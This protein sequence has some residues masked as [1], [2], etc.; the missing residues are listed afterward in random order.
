MHGADSL[1]KIILDL[2]LGSRN[3]SCNIKPRGGLRERALRGGGLI[4][5]L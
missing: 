5:D 1:L 2:S 3:E 4:F